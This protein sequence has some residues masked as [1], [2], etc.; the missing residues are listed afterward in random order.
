[1]TRSYEFFRPKGDVME[2][3]ETPPLV[4]FD[5]PEEPLP[6][7]TPAAPRPAT[8]PRQPVSSLLDSQAS[9]QSFD[10]ERINVAPETK[11]EPR[12]QGRERLPIPWC[13]VAEAW[14]DSEGREASP[15]AP[16]ALAVFAISV[17]EQY[18]ADERHRL[19][20]LQEVAQRMGGR[21]PS[22]SDSLW[23]YP[24][25]YFG[26]NASAYRTD[27]AAEPWQGFDAST[28][29]DSL[30]EVLRAYPPTA[31]LAFGADDDDQQVWV[32]WLHSDGALQLQK[33]T[34][35]HSDLRERTILVGP[36]R[37][38]FFVCGE[39]TGSHTNANGPYCE[40]RYLRDPASELTDCRLLVDL[41]HS[42]VKGSIYENPGPRLV[43]ELQ[44]LR[45]GVIQ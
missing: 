16:G 3:R 35:Q 4:E 40:N 17:H 27:G 20:L 6:K 19:L 41:A 37:A 44:L 12:P 22:G 28:V 42:R 33:I 45:F 30:P 18:P 25:G 8:R 36:M 29:R 21:V 23:I 43:H 39:F 24:G 10:C 38:A 15:Q 13:W 31:R 9:L 34:R 7:D 32:C 14:I 2:H 5:C 1:M 11:A 26:F